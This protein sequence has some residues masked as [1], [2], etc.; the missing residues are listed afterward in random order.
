MNMPGVR[1]P[2]QNGGGFMTLLKDIQALHDKWDAKGGQSG[3]DKYEEALYDCINE[4]ADVII[5][6]EK[7]T[8]QQSSSADA[9][10]QCPVCGRSW[11]IKNYNACQCGACIRAAD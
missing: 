8:S 2:A 1:L 7:I 5:K 11:D 3:D 4:L 9:D 6:H 10:I